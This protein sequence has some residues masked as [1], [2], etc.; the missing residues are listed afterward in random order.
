MAR[1]NDFIPKVRIRYGAVALLAHGLEP[2]TL[3]VFYRKSYKFGAFNDCATTGTNYSILI[4]SDS[5]SNV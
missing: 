1:D 5:L 4:Q 2:A 3:K